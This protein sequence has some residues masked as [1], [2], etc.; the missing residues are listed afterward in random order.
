MGNRTAAVLGASGLVGRELLQIL[1][2]DPGTTAIVVPTRRPLDL[3]K[4]KIREHV[5]DFEH[6]E[7]AREVLAVDELYCCLGTTIKKAGSQEAFRRV[8][9]DYPVSWA[10][11]AAHA[12]ARRALV[13]SAVGANPKSAVFYNR[14][15]GELDLALQDVPFAEGVKIVHPSLRLGARSERRGGEMVSKVA[16]QL[17]GPLLVGGLRRYRAIAASQVARA[18]FNAA[19][20]EP[21]GN[22]IYEGG[23][24]FALAA[25]S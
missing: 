23:A 21:A 9:F 13:V 15:K 11:E 19:R 7:S 12:G 3:G 1:T 17:L 8:D 10:R 20:R 22:R 18:L 2:Q 16:M 5:L 24:L 4:G 25:T 6:P 14:V